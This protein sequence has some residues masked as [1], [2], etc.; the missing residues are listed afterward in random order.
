MKRR[1]AAW[2]LPLAL[3]TAAVLSQAGCDV[4]MQD[5]NAKATDEWKRTYPLAEGGQVEVTNLNGAIEVSSAPGSTVEVVAERTAR[6]STDEEARKALSEIQIKEEVTPDKVRLEVPRLRTEGVHLGPGPSRSVLFRLRV[7]K[8]VS[9]RLSSRNGQIQLTDL[10]GAVNAETTNGQILATG[11]SGVLDAST[12]NGGIRVKATAVQTGGIRLDTTNGSI[13][14][15]IPA[16]AK[17]DISAR[18]VNGS[19]KTDG[20]AL[21]GEPTRRRYE[22]KLNGGGPLIELS[23]TNGGIRLSNADTAD[24]PGKSAKSRLE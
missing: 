14:L 9:V 2:L 17:A 7:P 5:L 22:G 15:G 8:N 10:G 18:C 11:L 1:S 24:Q 13:E 4:V 3:M 12:T 21:Q 6:G 23:T 20:L 16:S 19:F